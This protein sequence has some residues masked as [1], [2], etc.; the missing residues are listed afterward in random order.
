MK[1][2]NKKQKPARTPKKLKRRL[3]EPA[4]VNYFFKGGYVELGDTIKDSFS[5]LRDDVDDAK[6]EL[7]DVADDLDELSNIFYVLAKIVTFGNSETDPDAGEFFHSF[8]TIFK[9]IFALFKLIFVCVFT[10]LFTSI[11]AFLHCTI[12]MII[13][14]FAYT[15][16]VIVKFA[17]WIERKIVHIATSCPNCQNKYDLPYYRCECG[18]IHKKLVPS[19]YGIWVRK[20]KCGRKLR[21]TFL[22]GRDR[23][24]GTWICP[25]CNYELG[26]PMSRDI[27][28]PVTGGP[29]SGKTC[30]ISMAIKQIEEKSKDLG[31]VFQYR[32]NQKLGDDYLSNVRTLESGSLPRK[33]ADRKLRYYQFYLT[34]KK[35]KIKN[36]IS[37]CDVAGETYDSSIALG[38][39]IGFKYANAFLM[40]IDPLSMKEYREEVASKMDISNYGGSL[41]PIDEVLDLLVKDLESKF[42][43][44]ASEFLDSDVCVVFTKCDIPGIDDLIGDKAVEAYM[45]SH[46]IKDK[47]KAKNKVCEEFLSKY[48]EGNF[49]KDLHSKFKSIQFFSCS[50]LGHV[51]NGNTFAPVGVEEPLLWLIDKASQRINL[52]EQWGKKI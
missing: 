13:M 26:T 51:Q 28:I 16:F 46:K 36:L 39:Q 40:I 1:K 43:L 23:N 47:Y 49:I 18:A 6:D 8:V 5:R 31:L 33:T 25:N 21:T 4:Y 34:P 15:I 3:E 52:K 29:S 11:M 44:K 37:V 48:H 24:K 17:D 35:D 27:L 7:V 50:A 12:L 32:S 20:C 30:F 41:K 2:R 10:T 45:K 22:N 42:N 19:R 38:Q 14:I 9:F